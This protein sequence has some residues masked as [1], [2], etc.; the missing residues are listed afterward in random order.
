MSCQRLMR[1]F[2]GFVGDAAVAQAG[3]NAPEAFEDH[4][5]DSTCPSPKERCA[6]C[7][8]IGGMCSSGTGTGCGCDDSC[9]NGDNKPKCSDTDCQGGEDNHCTK[10]NVH[11]ECTPDPTKNC[12]D[13]LD[14]PFC[15]D[16]GGGAGGTCNADQNNQL[17]D[18]LCVNDD[19]SDPDGYEP[20]TQ[21]DS[22]AMLKDL[23]SLPDITDSSYSLPPSESMPTCQRAGWSAKEDDINGQSGVTSKIKE[24][25][26]SMDGKEVAVK[27]KGVDTVYK[28]YP[29]S[30][31]SY[32]LSAN[33][34]YQAPSGNKCGDDRK[35]SETECTTTL[36]EG[37]KSCDPAGDTF[38]V[39]LAGTCIEYKITLDGGRDPDS[40][41]WSPLPP[42]AYP[43]CDPGTTSGVK[44]N[45][46]SGL[47]PQFCD[48]VNKDK[49]KALSKDLTSTDFKT[50][51]SKRSLRIRTPPPSGASYGGYKFHFDWTGSKGTC[52]KDCSAAYKSVTSSLCG[53]A[54]GEQN[55][56][57]SKGSLDVGCGTYSYEVNPK[58]TDPPPAPE[59]NCNPTDSKT[60]MSYDTL[61]NNIPDFCGK[62]Q[63]LGPVRGGNNHKETYNINTPDV[64]DF[65][66]AWDGDDSTIYTEVDTNTCT[67]DLKDFINSCNQPTF[68]TDNGIAVP[69]SNNMNFKHGGS[70]KKDGITY[71]VNPTAI[72]HTPAPDDAHGITSCNIN[73]AALWNA[74]D[75][76]GYGVAS[77]DFG[78]A[79][80]GNIRKCGLL[81][82]W[83][84]EY[85]PLPA[86]HY[87]P[88]TFLAAEWHASG[89]LPIGHQMKDCVG[90]A[91]G[92]IGA[93][94]ATCWGNL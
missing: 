90:N 36:T 74:F 76:W 60:Y 64:A 92:T 81:T 61:I 23:D 13:V 19:D 40:P 41:P 56:M 22:L 25:C 55:D 14:T 51:D 89:R 34:W 86:D 7:H 46:F 58:P 20:F 15:K 38:G 82:H 85:Y 94:D 3:L 33:V 45:W 31:Y 57:S 43:Q 17:K 37:M 18:C 66:A 77:G 44:A 32:W 27:S 69:G 72:R 78:G 47:Y 54:G 10:N 1:L 42:S 87:K 11:C 49:V 62:L 35:I 91:I 83:S 30:Y 50:P 68:Q 8:A 59:N 24:W 71:T 70:F 48:E 16:C 2:I 39:T 5:D 21:A 65:T 84:F 26:K 53:R 4:P 9:P 28:M 79:L 67:Q 75:I 88:S 12:P 29:E 73:W 63:A 6:E 93:T 52:R 80:A